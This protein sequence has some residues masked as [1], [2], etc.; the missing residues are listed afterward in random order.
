V[1][2][3]PGCKRRIFN[4][5]RSETVGLQEPSFA[6]WWS[7][8][9]TTT[10]SSWIRTQLYDHTIPPLKRAE[11]WNGLLWSCSSTPFSVILK[12]RNFCCLTDL[13]LHNA[14]GENAKALASSLIVPNYVWGDKVA[15]SI[16][17]NQLRNFCVCSSQPSFEAKK[18]LFLLDWL[19]TS[20]CG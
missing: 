10:R 7:Y 19:A 8:M 1:D 17:S 11:H 5:Q 4:S 15:N 6:L 3:N 20:S 13:D 2:W 12:L 9:R 18:V 16:W 14:I